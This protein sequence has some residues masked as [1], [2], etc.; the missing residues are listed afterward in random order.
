[1]LKRTFVLAFLLT[2]G[3]ASA[4][5]A[6]ELKMGIIDMQK[7]VRQSEPGQNAMEQLKTKF[8]D[9]K[10]DLDTRKGAIDKMREDLQKQSLV[11]SQ[12]AK[13]DKEIEFKRKVRD[14]QDLFQS[15]QRKMKSEEERLS[16]PVLELIVTT[17]QGWGKQNGYT[18]LVD[19]NGAGVLYVSD[20]VDVTNKVIVE[21][22]KAW[23]ARKK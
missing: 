22:N 2:L 12:E 5:V 11:L 13:V 9:L 4:A 15:Y 6:E 14:F 20:A 16:Q 23:R 1:M 8:K 21:V 19:G 7:V 10:D 18:V 17:I 3:L